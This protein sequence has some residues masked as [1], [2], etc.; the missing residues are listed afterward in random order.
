[1]FHSDGIL[2][3]LAVQFGCGGTSDKKFAHPG[4][5]ATAWPVEAAALVVRCIFILSS[6]ATPKP[7]PGYKQS[8]ELLS[9]RTP[10]YRWSFPHLTTPYYL[11]FPCELRQ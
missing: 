7:V 10:K 11:S 8:A 5:Q 6:S 9:T 4:K 2:G 1:V 3:I